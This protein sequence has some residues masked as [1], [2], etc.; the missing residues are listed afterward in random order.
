MH[1]D[2]VTACLMNL[3]NKIV[4]RLITFLIINTNAVFHGDRRSPDPDVF[5]HA[6]LGAQ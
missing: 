2:R 3:V 1:N 5:V 6:F 4:Q